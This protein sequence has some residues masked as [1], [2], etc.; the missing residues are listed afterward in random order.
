MGLKWV[1]NMRRNLAKLIF[2]SISLLADFRSLNAGT[3][4]AWDHFKRQEYALAAAQFERSFT[5]GSDDSSAREGLGWCYYWL[6]RY[7]QAEHEFLRA[8]ELDSQSTGA[9]NGIEEVKKWRFLV[10]NNAWQLFYSK[11]YPNALA[12]FLSILEDTSGRLPSSELW[13]VHSGI[14]WSQYYLQNYA[15]AEREFQTILGIYH[16]NA[17][18]LK[19]LGFAQYQLKK[20][21]ESLKTL[22][23]ALKLQPD[24][25]DVQSMIGWNTF[26]KGDYNRALDEFQKALDRN[27]LLADG[28]YGK[29]WTYYKMGQQENALTHFKAAI[30]L[31]PY[32]PGNFALLDIIDREKTWWTLYPALGWS[33]YLAA[34][35]TSAAKL[36]SDGLTRLP[37]EVDLKRGLAF[38]FFKQGNFQDV[39]RILR[40]IREPASALPPIIENGQAEDGTN[41]TVRSNAGGMLGWSYYY[42]GEIPKAQTIFEEEIKQN[43]DWT[44]LY[45]GLGW[46]RLK[47]EQLIEAERFFTKALNLNPYYP[48]AL[49][50]IS[51]LKKTRYADFNA[52]WTSYYAGDSVTALTNFESIANT[53][54]EKIDEKDRWQVFSGIGYS[55]LALGKNKEAVTAFNKVLDLSPGNYY[56]FVGKARS[57]YNLQNYKDAEQSISLAIKLNAELSDVHALKGW[58][59]LSQQKTREAQESFERSIAINPSDADGLSGYGWCRAAVGEKE[60]AR[61]YLEKAL[62]VSA[63]HPKALE[64]IANLNK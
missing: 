40:E 20:H 27:S 31:S 29:A 10:F 8:L 34:D 52:A 15:A 6:G 13:Q 59:L 39:I 4:K 56:A 57:E 49:A 23:L 1:E 26:S 12:V 54:L 32:H 58:I 37:D 48:V 19:G 41:Y 3:E 43:P 55:R 53:A 61:I 30:Q 42:I 24:W 47:K 21:D 14:G 46:C 38:S 45:A 18:A 17:F 5:S 9:R 2:L 22:H 64:G 35:Y 36:F 44:D 7:D 60:E 28:C 33:Y 25:A 16:D 11:D 50:G 62:L 63:G 51:E